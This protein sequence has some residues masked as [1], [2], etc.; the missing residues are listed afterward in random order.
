[1]QLL[2]DASADLGAQVQ[3]DLGSF[4]RPESSY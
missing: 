2:H 4:T 3:V 1:M